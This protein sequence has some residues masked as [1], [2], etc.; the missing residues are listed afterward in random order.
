MKTVEEKKFGKFLE[1]KSMKF[2]P[3]RRLVL[4]E[5]FRNHEHF[6]AEDIMVSARSRGH[7]I[8]RAS[9]YRTLPLL[10]ESGLLR[11]VA[12]LE[13]HCHYEHVLGHQHHDHLI[14]TGCGKT[15]EFSEEHIEELQERICRELVFMPKSHKLE[16]FGLCDECSKKDS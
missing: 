10:A 4:Q 9:V 15:I 12:S 3:E 5:V 13:K 1:E 2:T 8:S 16:I 14:C 11:E 6:E 7:R